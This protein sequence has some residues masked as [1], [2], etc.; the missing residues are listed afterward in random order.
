MLELASG[1]LVS[2]YSAAFREHFTV[3]LEDGQVEHSEWSLL[4][5]TDCRDQ[6]NFPSRQMLLSPKAFPSFLGSCIH[7]RFK[8]SCK[9]CIIIVLHGVELP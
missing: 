5:A 2:E 4:D 3:L 7:D 8:K 9:L 6:V 1:L